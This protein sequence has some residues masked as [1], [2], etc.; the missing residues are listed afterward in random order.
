MLSLL[1]QALT[2]QS[3]TALVSAILFVALALAL[4]LVPVPYV[5]YSPGRAYDVLGLNRD[6]RPLVQI[7]DGA[8]YPTNGRLSMTTVSVSSAD[9]RVT[10][11][12]VVFAWFHRDH[13]A[14]PRQSVYDESKTS[15]QVKT[16]ELRMMSTSQGDAVVAGLRAANIPVEELPM[17]SAVTI[18]GPANDR[19]KPGDLL[20]Q[21]GGTPVQTPDQA[22]E[23]IRAHAV[24]EPIEFRLWRAGKE[25]TA[26][27]TSAASSS[28]RE[29]PA[30]GVNLGVGYRYHPRVTFGV[31]EQI[32]GPSAGLVFALA[33]YDRATP[34]QLI[35]GRWIAGTGTIDAEGKVGPIGGIK[36]KVAGARKAGATMFLVPRENCRDLAGVRTDMKL[37]RV[38]SLSSA[39]DSLHKLNTEGD[40][41]A[42]PACG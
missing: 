26:T 25:E 36:E 30:V 42:V 32:G 24:G 13:D 28:N 29:I 37:V 6:G 20:L 9:S 33:V 23:A 19:L 38:D 17:V 18:A 40:G 22:R 8:D 15:E 39:I 3:I 16:E 12:Q 5:V 14:L 35:D 11:P 4:A 27:V 21:V 41:A 1:R 34:G 2:R 31:D 10:L 7:T